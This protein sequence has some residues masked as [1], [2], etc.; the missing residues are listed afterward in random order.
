ME[1]VET[2]RRD[3]AGQGIRA[4][5]DQHAAHPGA[6]QRRSDITRRYVSVPRRQRDDFDSRRRH[7]PRAFHGDQQAARAILG[8]QFCVSAETSLRIDHGPRR[9]R[10]GDL[11][12]RQLRVVGNCRANA[13]DDYV[14][15]RTQAVQMLDSRWT[16]DVLRMAGCRRYPAIERLAELPDH[17]EIVDHSVPQGAKQIRPALR[18]RLLSP[19]KEVDKALP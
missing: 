3:E 15:K 17:N 4:A 6:S 5:L 16:I 2:S 10:S 19:T 12:D 11:S 18:Q 14:D 7:S 13:N 9:L 8:E 1:A